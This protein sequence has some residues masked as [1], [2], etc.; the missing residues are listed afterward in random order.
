[1]KGE[2][3]SKEKAISSHEKL[4]LKKPERMIKDKVVK[5]AKVPETK[6]KPAF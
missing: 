4:K 3:A 1:M 6:R 5:N 2:Y